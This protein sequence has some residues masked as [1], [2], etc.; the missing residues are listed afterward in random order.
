MPVVS[1]T[2]KEVPGAASRRVRTTCRAASRSSGRTESSSP[3]VRRSV[4]TAPL[5][6]IA[7]PWL[8][9]WARTTSIQRAGLPVTKKTSIPASSA[10][11]RA[12]TVRADSVLSSRSRVPSRSVAISRVT[13][14]RGV[15]VAVVTGPFSPTEVHVRAEVRTSE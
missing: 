11:A 9:T 2:A 7:V 4:T 8:W 15:S 14:G 1:S 3:S 12:A 13:A 5:A 10:A 6:Q